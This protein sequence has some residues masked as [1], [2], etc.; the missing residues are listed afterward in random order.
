MQVYWN[1]LMTRGHVTKQLIAT[2][3]PPPVL[4]SSAQGLVWYDAV[5]ALATMWEENGMLSGVLF[6]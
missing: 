2:V 1:S 5:L 4:T 3:D 6:E